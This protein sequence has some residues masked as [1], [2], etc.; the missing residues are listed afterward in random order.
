MTARNA[1][2][3]PGGHR[4]VGD[5]HGGVLWSG[6][7]D[8]RDE[9]AAS[10]LPELPFFSLRAPAQ[11]RVAI[12]PR[13]LIARRSVMSKPLTHFHVG[14][15]ARP[16]SRP[17]SPRRGIADGTGEAFTPYW[18]GSQTHLAASIAATQRSDRYLA[19]VTSTRG[20]SSD[21]GCRCAM[22]RVSSVAGR[23]RWYPWA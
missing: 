6:W 10:S 15:V 12:K 3:E 23:P 14:L 17:I 4:S 20:V 16:K 18:D 22:A 1:F 13:A 8:L 11:G 2:T 21:A 19:P 5:E 9:A 7:R